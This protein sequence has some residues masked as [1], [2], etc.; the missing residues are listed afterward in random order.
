MNTASTSS[1]QHP[2][3][4]RDAGSSRFARLPPGPGV[5]PRSHS[6]VTFT[7]GCRII[8]RARKSPDFRADHGC[9]YRVGRRRV[10][11]KMKAEAAAEAVKSR[12]CVYGIRGAACYSPRMQPINRLHFYPPGVGGH[13]EG[14]PSRTHH[15]CFQIAVCHLQIPQTS[16]RCMPQSELPIFATG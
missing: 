10:C 2:W 6:A 13:V 11:R 15:K 12:R 5:R 7:S 3:Y 1:R 9:A 16:S 14:V 4:P 8:T